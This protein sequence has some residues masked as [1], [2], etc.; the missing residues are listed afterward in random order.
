M[1]IPLT[2][3]E[4]TRL[5]KRVT[6]GDDKKLPARGLPRRRPPVEDDQEPVRPRPRGAQADAARGG[7]HAA[8]EGGRGEERMFAV[9]LF[10]DLAK[11]LA[12]TPSLVALS[13]GNVK[14]V[15]SELDKMK[16]GTP[17]PGDTT[18]HPHGVLLGATNLHGGLRLAF[19]L[20]TQG[21]ARPGQGRA[22]REG[23]ARVRRP[24]RVRGRGR[25][26]VRPVRRGSD[27]GRLGRQRLARSR[28]PRRRPGDGHE[29]Q[30]RALP[31]LPGPLRRRSG[32]PAAGSSCRTSSG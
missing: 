15:A 31:D 10:G 21:R 4:L 20:G 7:G 5:Q 23:G 9:V 6:T 16:P 32:R 1:L 19:R 8:A 27:V 12:S 26:R 24:P 2:P 13:A 29:A 22:R 14:A 25:H 17:K 11:T 18:P 28:G 3:E 30:G